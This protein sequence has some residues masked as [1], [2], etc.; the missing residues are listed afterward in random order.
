M[1]SH[2]LWAFERGVFWALD[3]EERAPPATTHVPAAPVTCEEARPDGEAA[4]AQ[5][6]EK[7]ERKKGKGKV[8][9]EQTKK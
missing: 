1:P 3:L 9:K 2:R 6:M 7:K 5:A 8:Y 4:L